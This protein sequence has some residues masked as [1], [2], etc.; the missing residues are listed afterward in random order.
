MTLAITVGGILAPIITDMVDR[1]EPLIEWVTDWVEKHPGAVKWLAGLALALV[2][3]GGALLGIGVALKGASIL[4]GL[5]QGIGAVALVVI[6]G[7]GL[8]PLLLI[9]GS[10]R[11]RSITD[12]QV[13]GSNQSVLCWAFGKGLLT[14]LTM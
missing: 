3:I 6:A 5:V 2:A 11:G 8:G 9:I 1:L 14:R 10:T 13:L 12:N 7:I 4:L